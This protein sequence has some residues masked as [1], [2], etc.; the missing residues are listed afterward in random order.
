MKRRNFVR[1]LLIAPAGSAAL[2]AQQQATPQ[3]PS[4]PLNTPAQ[5][6]PR[7]P[8][9]VPE[10]PLVQA[11]LAA[12]AA[13]HFFSEAQFATL[14]KL[15]SLL[16]PPLKGKP[17]AVEA[18]APEFLDF[19]IGVSAADRQKLYCAGLDSLN[20]QAT[21]HFHTSFAELNATQADA[22]LRPLF[23]VRPWPEDFPDDHLKNFIA[24]VHEDL[25][26]ATSNSREWANA[27]GA[28]TFGRGFNRS[29][30]YYWRPIDPIT[31]L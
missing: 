4:P 12:A 2:K 20:V 30:G 27:G 31:E 6:N 1:S 3:K 25:R 29:S 8:Q 9:G 22:I 17:G 21:D 14:K 5:Q 13:P 26:T 16:V 19:L 11:D 18:Q 10:L 15:A 28:H 23:V 7:Q 24:R